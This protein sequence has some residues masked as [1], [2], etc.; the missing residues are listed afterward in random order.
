M[1]TEGRDCG[2]EWTWR[3]TH[4]ERLIRDWQEAIDEVKRFNSEEEERKRREAELAEG[5]E[6]APQH[7]T[8]PPEADYEALGLPK[9]WG[10]VKGAKIDGQ[11]KYARIFIRRRP[12]A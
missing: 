8:S 2:A 3:F 1:A 7:H 11:Q 10:L 6:E 5:E 12:A 4:D 9:N